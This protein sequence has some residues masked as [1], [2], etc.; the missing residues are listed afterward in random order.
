MPGAV[1]VPLRHDTTMSMGNI[2]NVTETT[3]MGG[4]S[5][6][7]IQETLWEAR[8]VEENDSD[9]AAIDIE[10][11]VEARYKE[12]LNEAPQAEVVQVSLSKKIC[13]AV[14]LAVTFALVASLILTMRKDKPEPFLPDGSEEDKH[15][16]LQRQKLLELLLPM[17]YDEEGLLQFDYL[18]DVILNGE[19]VELT[20][21]QEAF[22]WL[23]GFDNIT[24]SFLNV[25]KNDVDVDDLVQTMIIER[26][27]LAVLYYGTKGDNWN[28][29]A[30]FLNPDTSVCE[31]QEQSAQ[32]ADGLRRGVYCDESNIT[33]SLRLCKS[34]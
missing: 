13:L 29:Q 30:D 26:Y 6:T 23:V 12:R 20:P 34:C 11:K 24:S 10:D 18:D 2:S 4:D 32:R 16:Q 33:S 3:A 5:N 28:Y 31:W 21:Q 8:L 14:T 9:K 7:S 19:F 27:A 25:T 22:N 15:T 1:R 17:Y